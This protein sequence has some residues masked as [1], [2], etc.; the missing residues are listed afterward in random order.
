M[1]LEE[2]LKKLL[3]SKYIIFHFNNAITGSGLR[4]AVFELQDNQQTLPRYT[5]LRIVTIEII[6]YIYYLRSQI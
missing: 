1:D 3:L 5:Q 6:L 2:K 4:E